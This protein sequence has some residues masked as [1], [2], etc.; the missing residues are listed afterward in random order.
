M[1]NPIF[2]KKT[3]IMHCNKIC[4][5]NLKLKEEV[6]RAATELT[7]IMH[8]TTYHHLLPR[9]RRAL[10]LLATSSARVTSAIRRVMST[11]G[12]LDHFIVSRGSSVTWRRHTTHTTTNS[13]TRITRHDDFAGDRR[14]GKTENTRTNLLSRG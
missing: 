7:R 5:S 9:P 13:S 2:C 12:A 4:D 10:F 1:K 14:G 6:C 3:T 11:R 8:C